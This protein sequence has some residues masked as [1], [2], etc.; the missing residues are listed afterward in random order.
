MSLAGSKS[1]IHLVYP[2]VQFMLVPGTTAPTTYTPYIGQTNTLTLPETI[3]GGEV[4][5]VTGEGRETW[6]LLNNPSSYGYDEGT[7]EGGWVQSED[8]VAW[9]LYNATF[10]S[11]KPKVLSNIFRTVSNIVSIEEPYTVGAGIN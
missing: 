10:I 5:A 8:A 11:R 4:D 3:Y 2:N 6:M 7:P 9:Y 1:G